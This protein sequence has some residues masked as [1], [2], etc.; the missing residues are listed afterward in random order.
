MKLV[1]KSG[2][3]EGEF[4]P[5]AL[6]LE[7]QEELNAITEITGSVKGV[8]KGRNLTDRAYHLLDPFTPLDRV[9]YYFAGSVECT[10]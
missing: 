7:T 3:K 9:S 4:R 8:G 1:Q 6:V 2:G 5:V 10:K